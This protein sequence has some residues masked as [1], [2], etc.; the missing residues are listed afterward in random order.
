MAI[1]LNP[2]VVTTIPD[3]GETWAMSMNSADVSGVEVIKAAVP[4]HSH[5]IM[6]ISL[7]SSA[8]MTATIG[9]GEAVAGTMDNAYFGPVN[10]TAAGPVCDIN[11]TTVAGLPL[12]GIKCGLGLPLCIDGTAGA[13]AI[14]IEGKTCKE[15]PW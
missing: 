3:D 4:G 2:I 1:T 14:Y 15:K 5:Y 11:F 10:F 6:K 8:A 13:I 7:H 12:K 9:A